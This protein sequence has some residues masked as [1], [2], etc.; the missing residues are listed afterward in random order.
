MPFYRTVAITAGPSRSVDPRGKPL[1][2]RRWA[3]AQ[4]AFL[5]L[6][7]FLALP[8]RSADPTAVIEAIETYMDFAEY[9]ASLIWPEQIPREDWDRVFVVD[10]RDAAQYDKGH[11]PGAAN[12]EW[13]QAVARR[14]ELPQDRMVVFYC[15]SGSLSAQAVFALRLLGHDNV[16]VL[17]DGFEGWKAKGGFDAHARASK[18][19][20]Y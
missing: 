4:M 17:Q 12:I 16:K 19:T 14:S 11:I 2:R 13:R 18:A 9:S 6:F 7:A 10:A 1:A 8:A 3:P 20:E 15:N 5:F